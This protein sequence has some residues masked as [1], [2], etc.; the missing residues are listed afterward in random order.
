VIRACLT[1][2]RIERLGDSFRMIFASL[3]LTWDEYGEWSLVVGDSVNA[4][5]NSSHVTVHGMCGNNNRRPLGG[6]STCPPCAESC[7]MQFHTRCGR[8]CSSESFRA[9]EAIGPGGPAG[10]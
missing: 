3:E 7:V 4:A 8:T 6:C 2:V 1:G 10:P 5:R 9:D